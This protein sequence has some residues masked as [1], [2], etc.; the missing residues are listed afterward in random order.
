VGWYEGNFK[1]DLKDDEGIEVAYKK[2]AYKGNFVNGLR[3]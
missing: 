2:W 3:H 1:N